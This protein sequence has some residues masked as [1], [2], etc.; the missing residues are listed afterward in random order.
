MPALEVRALPLARLVPAPYNPRREVPP[1][2]DEY[3]KLRA[4]LVAFGLVEPLVWNETTGHLVGGHLR[5]RVL[6]ELGHTDAPAAV[7]RLPLAREMAL[8]VV[9]NNRDAQGCF[10]PERLAAVL[11]ELNA[12]PEFEL[13]GFEHSA[14]AALELKP[15]ALAP[16]TNLSGRVEVV[17]V[18]DDHTYSQFARPLDALV[19]AHGLVAHVRRF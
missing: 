17:L 11:A 16:E 8:N 14:L 1:A 18:T 2:A 5:L 12:T 19:S 3:Q 15:D 13:T 4:S 7:V 6:K 9:L 10:E